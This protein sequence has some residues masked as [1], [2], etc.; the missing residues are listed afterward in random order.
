MCFS[1]EASF[2]SGLVVGT[3]GVATLPKIRHVSEIPLGTL[4]LLFAVHQIEEGMVWLF[5][6]GR[7]SPEVGHWFIW[8]YI[9]FA[10]AFLLALSPW[11]IWLVEPDKKRR[12]LLVPLL[13]LGTCLCAYALWKLSGGQIFA[14]IRKYGIEYEDPVT[15]LW[16]FAILYVTITCAPPFLSSYPWMIAFGVACLAGLIGTALFKAMYLT[17]MWCAFTALVSMLVYFH[18]RWTRRSPVVSPAE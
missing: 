8:L 16:W 6:E 7:I 10:H 17:S 14:Q 2:A 1:A 3:I 4:P 18:F 15:G 9:L 12:R 11:S 5:L 13:V